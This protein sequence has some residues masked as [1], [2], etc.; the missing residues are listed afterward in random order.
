L[1][2]AQ[3]E[4][5]SRTTKASFFI[6]FPPVQPKLRETKRLCLILEFQD[7]ASQIYI[8]PIKKIKTAQQ[9]QYFKRFANLFPTN[10]L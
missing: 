4:Q 1:L 2:T 7:L 10:P 8:K 6:T 5:H 9:T 3:K